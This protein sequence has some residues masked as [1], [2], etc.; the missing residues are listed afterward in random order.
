MTVI[1]VSITP[2]LLARLD[3]YVEKTGYSSRS[4]AI[5]LAVRDALSQ[6]ALRR[7]ERGQVVSTVTVISER[8]RHDLNSHL[9]DLRHEYEDSIFGNMH[10]HVGR[11]YCVEILLVQDEAEKVI[12]FVTRVRAL[13][14]IREVNYVLTPIEE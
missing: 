5:R 9:M 6:F 8:D 4:E 12:D 10:L 2:E 13:R 1:S 11:G 3:D 7:F 14:G